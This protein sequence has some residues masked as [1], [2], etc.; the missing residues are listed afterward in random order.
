MKMLLSI[1]IAYFLVSWIWLEMVFN[2]LEIGEK[3]VKIMTKR[4]KQIVDYR[5]IS[6]KVK[7]VNVNQEW[8]MLELLSNEYH[9]F[10]NNRPIAIRAAVSREQIKNIKDAKASQIGA[11]LQVVINTR[12]NIPQ[13]QTKIVRIAKYI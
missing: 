5:L 6:L 12:N 13:V 7:D 4:N 11:D 8:A 9:S 10:E 1:Y 3:H 2:K